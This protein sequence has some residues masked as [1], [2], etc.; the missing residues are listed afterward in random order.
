MRRVI[1]YAVVLLFLA[2]MANAQCLFNANFEGSDHFAVRSGQPYALTWSPIA[3]AAT[4]RVTEARGYPAPQLAADAA[5]GADGQTIQSRA[6]LRFETKHFA[7][8]DSYIGY[9]IS[10]FADD[11][12]LLCSEK[13]ALKIQ[14]DPTIRNLFRRAIVPVAGSLVAADGSKF[15]TSLRLALPDRVTASGRIIFHPQGAIHSDND[16]SITYRLEPVG[17]QMGASQYWDDVVAAMGAS[18]LGTLDIA[19]DDDRTPEIDARAWNDIHGL[20][21]GGTVPALKAADLFRFGAPDNFHFPVW[22]DNGKSRMNVGFRTVGPSPLRV[23]ISTQGMPANSIIVPGN[24]FRQFSLASLLGFIPPDGQ[25]VNIFLD[26]V[27]DFTSSA[28]V[29]YTITDNGSNDPRVFLPQKTSDL[30]IDVS[31]PIVY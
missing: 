11:G 10:A 5:A 12:T 25:P 23:F 6:P 9:A 31:T 21:N 4:Y 8:A 26:Y 27:G 16:P 24:S 2:G 20:I 15:H 13:L 17:D 19:P 28:F 30:Q 18:G 14:A 29:Y 7:S 1:L 22:T 3:G